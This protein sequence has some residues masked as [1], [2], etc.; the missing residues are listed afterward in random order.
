MISI[1]DLKQV[2]RDGANAHAGLRGVSVEVAAGE[3]LALLG[4]SGCGKTTL[5]R[6]IAGLTEPESG[7]IAI[8]G[9]TV[10]S[11]ARQLSVAARM[12]D[13]GMVFQ[14]YAIW[15]HM[16]VAQ[17]AAFPLRYRRPE[18]NA[19]QVR[20]RT[21]EVLRLVHLDALAD[22]SAPALSGGQQQRLALA[23]ALISDPKVLLLDEPLSN[24]DARLREEMRFELRAL[25]KR[26]G[27]TTIL[28]TH[29]QAEA[30]SLADIV[31][32]MDDGRFMQISSPRELYDRP[33]TEFV[34]GFVGRANLVPAEV[35]ATEINGSPQWVSVSTPYGVV[36]CFTERPRTAGERA[37]LAVQPEALAIVLA[38][39][40]SHGA[41]TGTV[42][43]V[44]FIG[45]A[46]ELV[47]RV[48]DSVLIAK[49]TTADAPAVGATVAVRVQAQ[50]CTLLS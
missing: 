47:V 35:I 45:D 16:S 20:E 32:V 49:V 10:Y 41:V 39:S 31:A 34:A 14:S 28:V 40:D 43:G 12:R 48:N 25:T 22:R 15:P 42:E 1:A 38:D 50:T 46:T 29:E 36:E 18:L 17:N 19:A 2:Y 4:P 23:R 7:T 3:F 6:C 27:V 26:L 9:E 8:D 37:T 11:G 44:A 24:L 33:R 5:L 30:L 13:I 21:A